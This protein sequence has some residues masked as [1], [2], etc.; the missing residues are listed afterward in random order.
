MLGMAHS[1]K[2]ALTGEILL[3]RVVPGAAHYADM[4]PDDHNCVIPARPVT[5]VPSSASSAWHVRHYAHITSPP[6]PP[7]RPRPSHA[8]PVASALA[9]PWQPPST[10]IPSS[11]PVRPSTPSFRVTSPILR[12]LHPRPLF[13]LRVGHGPSPPAP[14]PSSPSASASPRQSLP[15]RRLPP[16]PLLPLRRPSPPVPSPP[17]VSA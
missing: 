15:P 16:F 10:P 17:F 4:G 2:W 13:S 14:A 1:A 11:P 3:C 8:G 6:L 5:L 12:H 7:A 9:L